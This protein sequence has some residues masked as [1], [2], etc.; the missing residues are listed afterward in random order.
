MATAHYSRAVSTAVV[1]AINNAINGG[2]GDGTIKFYNAPMPALTSDGITTQTLLGTCAC[3]DPAGVE[4]GGTLTFSAIDND[5]S[6]DATG[7]AAW[8]RIADSAGTV[9]MDLDVTVTG[10]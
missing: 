9:V 6:A 4:A 10:G 8:V 5:V 7:T 2:A 1:T 3:A